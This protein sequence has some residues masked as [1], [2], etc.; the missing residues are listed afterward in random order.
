MA[1]ITQ[2]MSWF[3]KSFCDTFQK[4]RF[5]MK[6]KIKVVFKNKLDNQILDKDFFS[7]LFNHIVDLKKKEEVKNELKK[8]KDI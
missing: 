3:L 5:A 7:L 2:I 1:G 4:R 6:N 8:R